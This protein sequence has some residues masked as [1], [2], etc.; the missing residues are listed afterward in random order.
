MTWVK[1]AQEGA[2]SLVNV[3]VNM[4][5]A[6]ASNLIVTRILTSPAHVFIANL[7]KYHDLFLSLGH[8]IYA[9]ILCNI[10]NLRELMNSTFFNTIVV[11]RM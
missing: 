1:W 11:I 7:D 4:P 9:T 10:A 6:F 2:T 5:M 8:V 3:E